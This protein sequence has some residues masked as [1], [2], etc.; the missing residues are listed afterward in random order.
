MTDFIY[1]KDLTNMKL[2]I[3]TCPFQRRVVSELSDK[4]GVS[5]PKFMKVL[6]EKLDM[7][8]LENLPSRY[9]SWKSETCESGLEFGIGADLFSHYIPLIDEKDAAAVIKRTMKEIES[10]KSREEAISEGKREISGMIFK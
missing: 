4:Y 6:M 1:E 7:S 8:F 3:L 5:H 9:G 2:N 10:G